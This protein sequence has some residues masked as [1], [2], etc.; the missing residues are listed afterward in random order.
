MGKFSS[1]GSEKVIDIYVPNGVTRQYRTQR[2]R[3]VRMVLNI[4]AEHN[5]IADKEPSGSL[6]GTATFF[7]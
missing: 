6:L 3:V 7:T 2:F 5:N 1:F 4:P